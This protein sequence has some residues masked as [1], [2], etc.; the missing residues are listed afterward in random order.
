MRVC[1]GVCRNIRLANVAILRLVGDVTI[2]ISTIR[3]TR[4]ASVE[5]G[6]PTGGART[7]TRISL[8]TRIVNVEI[9]N[10]LLSSCQYHLSH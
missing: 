4:I 1:G 10:D 7:V 9:I 5:T 2:V 8:N 6:R 3:S